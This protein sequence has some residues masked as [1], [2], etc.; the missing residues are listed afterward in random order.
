MMEQH[1]MPEEVKQVVLDA[2][3]PYN[4]YAVYL[5][6]SRLYGFYNKDS[7]YDVV[8]FVVPDKEDLYLGKP[9]VSKV[10]ELNNTLVEHVT[11]KDVRYL[12]QYL[13]KP[14]YHNSLPLF[15]EPFLQYG[16]T[17]FDSDETVTSLV[18]NKKSFLFSVGGEYKNRV[19]KGQLKDK[20]HALYL[21][22]LFESA[23]QS[24]TLPGLKPEECLA[25]RLGEKE[26]EFKD[27]NFLLEKA[28]QYPETFDYG[29][30][31]MLLDMKMVRWLEHYYEEY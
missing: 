28:K 18:F 8:A 9:M 19:K 27:A 11:V 3:Q 30:F 14:S 7:D 22:Q 15:Q 23:L 6:G 24:S 2:L 26:Y 12:L 13:K 5:N 20:A 16:E 1:N 29:N 31:H 17:L 10:L 21:E 4:V 25:V